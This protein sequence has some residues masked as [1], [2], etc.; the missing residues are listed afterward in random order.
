MAQQMTVTI[1]T[2]N[3]WHRMATD[4]YRTGRNWFGH[5]FSVAATRSQMPIEAYDT[6][7]EQYRRWLIGGWAEVENPT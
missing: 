7:M 1:H 2:M 4:A 3:E 6:L 5:R